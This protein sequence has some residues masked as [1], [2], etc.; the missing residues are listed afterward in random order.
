LCVRTTPFGSPVEPEVK[1]ISEIPLNFVLNFKESFV[2][3]F[4]IKK[5]S[6]SIYSKEFFL[7]NLSN[8][9]LN[10]LFIRE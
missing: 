8:L 3:I 10:F 9:F 6:S 1:R 4:E 5:F 2:N 7:K